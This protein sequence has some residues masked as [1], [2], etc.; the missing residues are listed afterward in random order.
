MA[1][2][3]GLIIANRPASTVLVCVLTLA[4]CGA[5]SDDLGIRLTEFVPAAVHGL[6]TDIIWGPRPSPDRNWRRWPN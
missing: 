5:Q 3:K 6:S 4:A 1:L 2:A